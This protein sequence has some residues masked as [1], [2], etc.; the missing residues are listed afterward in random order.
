MP[1]DLA[2]LLFAVSALLANDALPLQPAATTAG[3]MNLSQR[4]LSERSFLFIPR[5]GGAADW[6]G[7]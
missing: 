5:P 3:R 6:E 2:S 4:S 1:A 7:T